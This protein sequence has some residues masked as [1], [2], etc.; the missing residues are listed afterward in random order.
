MAAANINDVIIASKIPD[1]IKF[2]SNYDGDQQTLH[3]WITQVENVLAIYDEVRVTHAAIYNVWLGIIR[4][5]VQ[6]KANEALVSRNVPNTWAEI[7][8]VL[9][10]YFADKRDLS[11]LCQQIPYLRQND[12]NVGTFYKEVQK[13]SSNINQKIALDDRYTGHVNAVMTFVSEITK[14]ASQFTQRTQTIHIS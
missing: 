9:I 8:A 13:L 7:K 2:L 6:G 5:K 11:T 12:K 14:N 4:S 10:D 3:H 1:P